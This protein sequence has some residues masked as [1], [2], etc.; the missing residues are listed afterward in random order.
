MSS[1]Y[2]FGPVVSEPAGGICARWS[3]QRVVLSA[4]AG[5]K[6]GRSNAGTRDS[7]VVGMEQR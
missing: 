3:R 2:T 6:Y 1:G 5:Q 7:L 4:L